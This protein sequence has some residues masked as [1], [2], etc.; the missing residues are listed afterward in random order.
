[1][2][3]S[4]RERLRV[5]VGGLGGDVAFVVIPG[6]D[7]VEARLEAPVEASVGPRINWYRPS[8]VVAAATCLLDCPPPA[9]TSESSRSRR[10]RP[11]V[12]PFRPGDKLLIAS[13]A[14]PNFCSFR[15]Q[16]SREKLWRAGL[17]LQLDWRCGKVAP[18]CWRA[19]LEVLLVA[20]HRGG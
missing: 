5:P 4:P 10:T 15:L 13:H 8:G 14:C 9:K 7:G 12:E 18:D 1:M 6:Q 2:T 16:S 3:R 11:F 19:R 17:E 20:P